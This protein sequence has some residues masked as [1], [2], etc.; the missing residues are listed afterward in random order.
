MNQILGFKHLIVF[1]APTG[2]IHATM[3][4]CIVIHPI[5]GLPNTTVSQGQQELST[6]Y[7]LI[8]QPILAFFKCFLRFQF[9]H[10]NS[11][12]YKQIGENIIIV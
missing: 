1:L 6:E 12:F 8:T 2:A 9:S 10:R 5:C 4:H 11:T 3:R 7:E